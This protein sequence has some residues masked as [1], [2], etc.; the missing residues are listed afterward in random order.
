V[1]QVLRVLLLQAGP[2]CRLPAHLE[3]PGMQKAMKSFALGLW[4]SWPFK[5]PKGWNGQ[6]TP[7]FR[8]VG[9]LLVPTMVLS[10]VLNLGQFMVFKTEKGTESMIFDSVDY[11]FDSSRLARRNLASK[12]CYRTSIPT[13]IQ[14]HDEEQKYFCAHKRSASRV[15]CLC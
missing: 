12:A 11:N 8:L 14:Y 2:D 5:S 7:L 13:S 3:L 1:N 10:N 4:S 15:L 6:T 9:L